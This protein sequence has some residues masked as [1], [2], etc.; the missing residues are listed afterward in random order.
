[1]IFIAWGL[2]KITLLLLSLSMHFHV[3]VCVGM[4]QYSRAVAEKYPSG[5]AMLAMSEAE[6][7]KKLTITNPLHR[8]K[9]TLALQEMKSPQM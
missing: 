8:R 9:L 4:G 6:M 1:M 2:P 3:C 7:E 5:A